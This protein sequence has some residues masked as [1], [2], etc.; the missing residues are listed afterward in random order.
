MSEQDDDWIDALRHECDR[1]SQDQA[2]HLIGYSDSV[3]SQV[4]RGVYRGDLKRV[5]EAVRGALLGATVECPVIGDI[6]RNRCL[7]HQRR[8]RDI[9]ATN[10]LRVQLAK[11][12]PTC[13][14]RIE[15]RQ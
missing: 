1:T 4:L 3:V 12:C 13:P 14:N 15:S 9:A 8:A 11:A 10:P 7:D 6:P 5:E 2:G